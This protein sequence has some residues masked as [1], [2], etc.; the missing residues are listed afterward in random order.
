MRAE[1]LSNVIIFLG[2]SWPL[3]L[4]GELTDTFTM[5][6]DWRVGRRE[7]QISTPQM[8]YTLVIC[9]SIRHSK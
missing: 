1:R 8:V 2:A 7:P 9:I 4:S 3:R 6:Q 5:C